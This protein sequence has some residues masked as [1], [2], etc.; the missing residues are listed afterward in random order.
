M[1]YMTVNGCYQ[2]Y[3]V[4]YRGKRQQRR[5]TLPLIH[6]YDQPVMNNADNILLLRFTQRFSL[7][8]LVPLRR[9]PATAGCRRMLRDKYRMAPHRRLLTII[10]R[11]SWHQSLGDKIGGVFINHLRAFIP[12]ILSFFIP[13][14][15]RERN[16]DRAVRAKSGSSAFISIPNVLTFVLIVQA[17]RYL[18]E[19]F[20]QDPAPDSRRQSPFHA[21][22]WRQYRRPRRI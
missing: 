8:N 9:A 18:P 11:V 4:I 14:R 20:P 1:R 22:Q 12:A 7:R 15:K 16:V 17:R 21:A 2:W 19:S 3:R 10:R 13:R 6:L 5:A